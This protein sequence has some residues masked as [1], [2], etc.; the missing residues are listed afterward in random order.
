MLCDDI[1]ADKALPQN[2]KDVDKVQKLIASANKFVLEQDFALAADGLVENF[3][4]LERIAPFCRLPYPLVWIEFAQQH[5][6]HW[7]DAPMY[8]PNYQSA[9]QRIGFLAQAKDN[10]LQ[11]W[12]TCLC[13]SLKNFPKINNLAR[14]YAETANWAESPNNISVFSVDYDISIKTNKLEEYVKIGYMPFLDHMNAP[15]YAVNEYLRIAQTD[16]LGEIRYLF[17]VLGLLNA[18]NVVEQSTTDYT[19][20]NRARA[21]NGKLPLFEHK[22]LRIRALHR[23][24]LAPISS[25]KGSGEV[26]A[27]FVRGHFKQRATGL[28]WWGPHVRNKHAKGFVAKDYIVTT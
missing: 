9:P 1:V 7:L 17:A 13:W 24:S 21:R 27:C 12:T 15:D 2:Y 26:R 22:V 14:Q 6:A 16:W 23:P 3:K 28:F 19:K 18:R 10:S 11:R 20:L 8:H 5:R 4:E 25:P